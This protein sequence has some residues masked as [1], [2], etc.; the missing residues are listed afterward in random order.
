MEGATL[1]TEA[2]I[3]LWGTLEILSF[4]TMGNLKSLIILPVLPGR[5]KNRL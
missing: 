1:D 5:Q 2:G 3:K 4:S